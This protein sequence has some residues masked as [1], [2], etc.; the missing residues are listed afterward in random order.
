MQDILRP[1]TQPPFPFARLL[2]LWLFETGFHYVPGICRV[3]T[4]NLE[5]ST[6]LLPQLLKG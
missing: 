5:F 6:I 2:S 1:G 3:D 4:V